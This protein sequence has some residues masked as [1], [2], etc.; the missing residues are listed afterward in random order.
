VIKAI[1]ALLVSLPELLKLIKELQ[2][3]QDKKAQD[4]KIKDD[5]AAIRKAFEENDEEALR[6]IFNS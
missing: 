3:K 6:D 2:K 5:V 4:K 1:I